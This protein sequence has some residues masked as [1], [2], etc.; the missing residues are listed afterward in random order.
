[1]NIYLIGMPGSGK[2]TLGK[3]LAQELNYSF[4]DMDEEI[5]KSERKTIN[6]IFAEEGEEE[7]RDI[8]QDTLHEIATGKNLVVATGGGV[9]CFF[10]NMQF[11]NRSGM[12][13][14]IDVS[15][16]ELHKRIASNTDRPMFL[17][18]T[19][20]EIE[21][22]LSNKITSRLPFYSQA[23]ITVTGDNIQLEDLIGGLEG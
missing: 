22:E 10:D 6:E 21:T 20:Q 18:K 15:A 23:Q 19:P 5:E 12:S 9:P 7:F 1:M 4:V 2:T 11:I 8:E 3:Q 14:F 16:K 17:Y 13:I